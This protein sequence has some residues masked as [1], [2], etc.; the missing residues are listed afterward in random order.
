MRHTDDT[1]GCEE[2]LFGISRVSSERRRR[3][4]LTGIILPA[5]REKLAGG[6]F[7]NRFLRSPWY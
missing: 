3:S 1:I 7:K 5:V 4:F 6:Q 2:I